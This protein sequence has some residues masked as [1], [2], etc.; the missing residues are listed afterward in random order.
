MRKKLVSRSLSLGRSKGTSI[1]GSVGNSVF[2]AVFILH[3]VYPNFMSP[4]APKTMNEPIKEGTCQ[5]SSN[6]KKFLLTLKAF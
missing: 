1:Q 6:T 4:W 2:L 5:L 3:K